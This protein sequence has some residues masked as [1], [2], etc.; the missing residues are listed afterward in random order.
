MPTAVVPEFGWEPG[1]IHLEFLNHV[2]RR[3]HDRI[4]VVRIAQDGFLRVDSV[5][6]E[7]ESAL[8]LANRVLPVDHVHAGHIEVDAIERLLQHGHL[9]E[10]LAFENLPAGG[11][12]GLEQRRGAGD[13]YGFGDVTHFEADIEAGLFAGA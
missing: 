1:G 4:E 7:A 2:E 6:S 10:G 13:L 11:R 9:D 12:L 3:G 8:A 5:D